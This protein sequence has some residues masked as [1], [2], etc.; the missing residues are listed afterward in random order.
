MFRSFSK[1]HSGFENC[2][3]QFP[4]PPLIQRAVWSHRRSAV[5]ESEDDF[6]FCFFSSDERLKEQPNDRELKRVIFPSEN[7]SNLRSAW[8][9]CWQRT[10]FHYVKMVLMQIM[11]NCTNL[12]ILNNK[13]LIFFRTNKELQAMFDVKD[14]TEREELHII[15]TSSHFNAVLKFLICSCWTLFG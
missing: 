6:V 10:L 12:L 7:L 5:T 15:V 13:T 14:H 11:D 8:L 2:K 1:C 4:E 3:T 9:F